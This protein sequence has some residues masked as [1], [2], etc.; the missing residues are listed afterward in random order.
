VN[1]P[2]ITLQ[3]RIEMKSTLLA[4]LSMVIA[5][6]FYYFAI[7]VTTLLVYA[8]RGDLNISVAM[9]LVL[10]VFSAFAAGI[11]LARIQ[12][13]LMPSLTAPLGSMMLIGCLTLPDAVTP[14]GV[15]LGLV[16]IVGIAS[17]L[18]CAVAAFRWKPNK[19]QPPTQ[20]GG[21]VPSASPP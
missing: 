8:L 11:I 17:L 14:L 6:I 13:L 12:P 3:G 2:K 1:K 5:A 20:A 16:A 4:L 10:F 7:L 9:G 18:G 19:T 15:R 21:S